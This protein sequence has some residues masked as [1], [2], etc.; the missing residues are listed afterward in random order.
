MVPSPEL[1]ELTSVKSSENS[2][3]T[4]MREVIRCEK[5]DYFS[6]RAGRKQAF[7][8]HNGVSFW[9]KRKEPKLVL[10]LPQV[11]CFSLIIRETVIKCNQSY[12]CIDALDE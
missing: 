9:R 8:N 2:Q 4:P 12:L 1:T 10:L 3:A 11:G 6:R 5:K 7:K